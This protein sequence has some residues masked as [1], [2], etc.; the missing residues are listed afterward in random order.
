MVNLLLEVEQSKRAEGFK[1]IAGVDEAGRGP[2]AGPVVAAAVVLAEGVEPVIG[3]GDSKALT[4]ARREE[5]FTQLTESP[6][7]GIGVGIVDVETIDRINIFQASLLAMERAVDALPST[8][9]PDI[10]IVDGSHAPKHLA[11]PAETLVKGDSRCYS[12]AA[13]SIVAKVTRDRMMTGL[14]EKHPEYGFDKH[15]GYGTRAHVDALRKFGAL[16]EHRRS[17]NPL[18]TWVRGG[19]HTPPLIPTSGGRL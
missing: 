4:P 3:V 12:I 8:H 1:L 2:L 6:G 17:F 14:H 18:K 19:V 7:V 11:A 10:V 9:T 13:A 5:L 15:M 16:P